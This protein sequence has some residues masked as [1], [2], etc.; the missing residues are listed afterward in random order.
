MI[1]EAPLNVL[2]VEDSVT[3]QVLL[4]DVINSDPRLR[5]V[6]VANSG[7]KALEFL[8]AHR[9]DV[10]VMDI[11]LPG[12]DG[13]ETTRR[14]MAQWPVPIIICSA[15]EDPEDVATTFQAIDVGALA[16][17]AK[18][19]GAGDQHFSELTMNLVQT[20]KVMSEVKVVRRWHRPRPAAVPA[21]PPPREV[22]HR[23]AA[24]VKVVAIGTSTGGPPILRM[25]LADLPANFSVPI[26]VVQHI[27]PGFLQGLVEWLS[28]H[29]PLPI[30]IGLHGERPLPGRVYFA[31]DG[32]H[33]GVGLHGKIL[34]SPRDAG[35]PLCPSV[36]HLFHS[37]ASVH[38]ADCVAV[39]L[40]G[41]GRDG[42][43][44][45][46]ELK[47]RGATT[48]AQD[49]ATSIV[50]GMPGEAIRLGGA[51]YVLAA[52]NI[53]PALRRLLAPA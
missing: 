20:I 7:E 1:T 22:A 18:P 38:G 36:S 19:A 21:L 6:S 26:L 32:F 51:S 28:E 42:A 12:I 50:H 35:D 25:I 10:I 9:P 5:V 39:L 29:T 47:Q 31:P 40:T 46:A 27:A 44:E 2:L 16:V 53:A 49:R 3:V 17:L 11:H 4:T 13:F 33:M 43:A 30:H 8:A 34:L 24:R 45:L 15:V 14:I 37:M 41:M 23:S 48:I 52:E